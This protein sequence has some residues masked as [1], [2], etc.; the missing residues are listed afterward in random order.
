MSYITFRFLSDQQGDWQELTGS[1]WIITSWLH[2]HELWTPSVEDT[3]Q[4]WIASYQWTNF[5]PLKFCYK[6]FRFWFPSIIWLGIHVWLAYLLCDM[7]SWY[8][9]VLL[10]G[11][12]RTEAYWY[13]MRASFPWSRL[14]IMITLPISGLWQGLHDFPRV[15]H[16]P[17]VL[18]CMPTSTHH[19]S[20]CCVSLSSTT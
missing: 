15:S 2:W 13:W 9:I 14:Y 8:W 19:F 7:A 16:F 17:V 6:I 12:I 11:Y 4:T 5:R 3:L 10:N 18:A 1:N 20:S